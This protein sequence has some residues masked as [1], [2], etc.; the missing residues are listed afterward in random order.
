MSAEIVIVSVQCQMC[1]QN[2][3]VTVNKANFERWQ[4]REGL[5]QNL[6][7]ELSDAERELL[8]SHMCKS[9]FQRLFSGGQHE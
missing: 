9:C 2:F 4:N 7:P 8:I 3:E 5:I 6:M 1:Q